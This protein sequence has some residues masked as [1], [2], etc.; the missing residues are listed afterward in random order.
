LNNPAS[1][2]FFRTIGIIRSGCSAGEKWG[3]G[4]ERRKELKTHAD[5]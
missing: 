5:S 3:G 4:V 2:L 1:V